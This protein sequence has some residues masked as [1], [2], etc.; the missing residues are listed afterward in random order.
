MERRN[1][2]LVIL[3]MIEK[4]PKTEKQLIKDLVW[5][6]NDAG[7]KAPEG[8]LQWQ[9]THQTLVKHIGDNPSFGWQWEILSIISTKSIEELKELMSN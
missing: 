6:L 3:D 1:C 5:N 8:T 4:I 9:R 7:Y 2:Q